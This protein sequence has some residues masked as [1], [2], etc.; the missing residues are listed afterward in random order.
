LTK[1]SEEHTVGSH[2]LLPLF[3]DI[4]N[5]HVLVDG[6]A[7][8][9]ERVL[10][11]ISL[12]GFLECLESFVESLHLGVAESSL[13]STMELFGPVGLIKVLVVLL[14]VINSILESVELGVVDM[15]T[16]W[17]LLDGLVEGLS[18]LSPLLHEGLTFSGML[19]L[20]VKCLKVVDLIRSSPLHGSVS[21]VLDDWRVLN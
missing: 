2:V 6:L 12:F 9:L 11:L 10:K 4:G 13:E 5:V 7:E 1:C 3:W 21:N 16:S 20:T 8:V 14:D 18:E 19:E 17:G 15:D